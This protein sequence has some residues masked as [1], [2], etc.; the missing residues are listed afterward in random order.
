MRLLDDI[1]VD[2]PGKLVV[3]LAGPTEGVAA[4]SILSQLAD[5]ASADR[6]Q[7]VGDHGVIEALVEAMRPDSPYAAFRDRVVFRRRDPGRVV[8]YTVREMAMAVENNMEVRP[9][10]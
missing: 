1:I 2:T 5:P 9:Q 6:T 7:S 10:S 4:S 3:T 8:E